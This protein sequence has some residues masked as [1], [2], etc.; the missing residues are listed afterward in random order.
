MDINKTRAS[1]LASMQ[2]ELTRKTEDAKLEFIEQGIQL[3]E[4]ADKYPEIES[5]IEEMSTLIGVP[6]GILQETLDSYNES[7]EG[8]ISITKKI[9]SAT[10]TVYPVMGGGDDASGPTPNP[11]LKDTKYSQDQAD[12]KESRDLARK[13]IL[14][15]LRTY[16]NDYSS[17][18]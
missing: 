12:D 16:D 5:V 17:S 13:G 9:A 7:Y 8:F 3:D 15:Y 11:P 1:E 18:E 6:A 14:H 4:I 2:E 10:G